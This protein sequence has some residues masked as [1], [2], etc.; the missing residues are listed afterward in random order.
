MRPCCRTECRNTLCFWPWRRTDAS[1]PQAEFMARSI[2]RPTLKLAVLLRD[3]V[4]NRLH[5]G[6]GLY[7]QTMDHQYFGGINSMVP[8]SQLWWASRQFPMNL[9]DGLDRRLETVVVPSALSTFSPWHNFRA[10]GFRAEATL[11]FSQLTYLGS[12]CP[13]THPPRS[14]SLGAFAAGSFRATAQKV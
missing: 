14:L 3:I 9:M 10:L 7:T 11:T 2:H 5:E 12:S 1:R 8:R 13:A 4:Q 6:G